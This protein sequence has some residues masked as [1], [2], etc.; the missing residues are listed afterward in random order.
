LIAYARFTTGS[1]VPGMIVHALNNALA[2]TVLA[3]KPAWA[4]DTLAAEQVPWG[5]ALVAAVPLVAG[6]F[7]MRNSSRA[8][9]GPGSLEPRNSLG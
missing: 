3:T 4:D 8:P 7:L 1:I 9:Q 5:M 6:I 2:V